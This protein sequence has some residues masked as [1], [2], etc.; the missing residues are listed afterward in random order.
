MTA[1]KKKLQITGKGKPKL[2]TPANAARV[3][4]LLHD[5]TQTEAARQEIGAWFDE[6]LNVAGPS[7]EDAPLFNIAFPAAARAI[8]RRP[9]VRLTRATVMQ[10]GAQTAYE[11]IQEILTRTAKGESLDDIAR[12]REASLRATGARLRQEQLTAPEPQDK[13]SAEWRS[14]VIA[15]V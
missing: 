15:N 3:F 2:S 14:Y 1:A 4:A 8:E 9:K 6:L 13:L 11:Q 7:L 5:E 10:Y 12:E